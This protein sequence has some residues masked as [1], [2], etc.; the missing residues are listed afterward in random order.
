M[1]FENV[2]KVIKL[3]YDY[4]PYGGNYSDTVSDLNFDRKEKDTI[5][6]FLFENSILE[7]WNSGPQHILAAKGKL[8]V[9]KFG[10]IEKYLEKEDQLQKKEHKLEK[11]RNEK[12]YN[13]SIRLKR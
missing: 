5:K 8:I 10:T 9:E 4:Q 7:L 13:D 11:I 3:F 12:L 2:D 6:N 1:N